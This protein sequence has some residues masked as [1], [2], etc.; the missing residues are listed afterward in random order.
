[1]YAGLVDFALRNDPSEHMLPH[2]ILTF[3]CAPLD[4]ALFM[5]P[6]VMISLGWG[7]LVAIAACGALQ[8][9]F[10]LWFTRPQ[11]RARSSA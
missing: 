3:V 2:F 8:A 10:L 5:L 4:I 1:M 11:A 7:Q 6:E 9:G